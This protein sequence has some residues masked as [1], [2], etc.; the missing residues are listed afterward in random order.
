MSVLGI[1][2]Q[3]GAVVNLQHLKT[4]ECK[5]LV[6]EERGHGFFSQV[7]YEVH[8]DGVPSDLFWDLS[9]LYD[10]FRS[11]SERSLL[12][13]SFYKLFREAA[14]ATGNLQ[15]IHLRQRD[16]RFFDFSLLTFDI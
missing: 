6:F 13:K 2:E 16:D 11:K 1:M 15:A 7:A 14:E 10:E 9:Y 12:S 8:R 4:E 5:L 3:P